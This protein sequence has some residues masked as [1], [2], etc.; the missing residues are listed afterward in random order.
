MKKVINGSLYNT[1][2]ARKLGNWDN[3][4]YG[5][6][7]YCEETLYRTK[8]GKYFIHG[9][10]GANSRY[11]RQTGSN[12]WSGGEKIITCTYDEAREWAEEHLDGDDYIAAF[13]EPAE[14]GA[15][16]CLFRLTPAV[17]AQLGRE[18]SK[19][20][21]TQSDIVLAALEAYFAK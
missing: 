18:V 11:S 5:S 17:K 13:G 16:M 2:T 14:D 15:E 9:E 6:F 7:G 1:E 20:G 4:E 21:K 12:S 10:G 3:G 8:S 19:T